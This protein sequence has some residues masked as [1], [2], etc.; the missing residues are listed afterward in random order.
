MIL[1]VIGSVL[2]FLDIKFT[3]TL[4]TL[5]YALAQN[6]GYEHYL[7]LNALII[8]FSSIVLSLKIPVFIV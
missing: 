3:G 2:P 5:S 1:S 6:N 4:T 8:S 7:N